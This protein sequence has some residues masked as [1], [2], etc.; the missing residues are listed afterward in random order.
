MRLQ[1]LDA[2][3]GAML[4]QTCDAVEPDASDAYSFGVEY[5]DWE[6]LVVQAE[7]FDGSQLHRDDAS[8]WPSSFA[9]VHPMASTRSRDDDVAFSL[10]FKGE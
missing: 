2:F 1:R 8:A 9:A 3:A 7:P 4:P 10:W 6:T 5:A